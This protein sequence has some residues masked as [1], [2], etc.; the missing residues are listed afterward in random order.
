MH[1]EAICEITGEA[2][3]VKATN[4]IWQETKEQVSNFNSVMNDIT[5]VFAERYLP[6]SL[7]ALAGECDDVEVSPLSQLSFRFFSDLSEF[8]AH[9]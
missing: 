4:I 7:S 2:D 8:G 9:K 1:Y 6:K 3:Y 5:L